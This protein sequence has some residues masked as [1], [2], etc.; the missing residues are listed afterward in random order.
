M[1]KVARCLLKVNIAGHGR[2]EGGL[3]GL[4]STVLVVFVMTFCEPEVV[5]EFP[6]QYPVFIDATEI[7]V[8]T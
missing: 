8:Y 2:Q 1:A 7:S 4:E 3:A 5:S 6:R